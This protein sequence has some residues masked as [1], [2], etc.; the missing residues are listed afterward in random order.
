MSPTAVVLL[1]LRKLEGGESEREG[2][3]ASDKTVR[4]VVSQSAVPQYMNAESGGG[5]EMMGWDGVCCS[6]VNVVNEQKGKKGED[7]CRERWQRRGGGDCS[8]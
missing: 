5:V 4:Q 8:G 7:L 1:S 6:E 2:E 3:R